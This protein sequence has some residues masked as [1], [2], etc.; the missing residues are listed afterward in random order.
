MRPHSYKKYMLA[1]LMAILAFNS[2]DRIALGIVLQ[3]IKLDF[4]LSDT[5]LGTLSGIAF[6][7]FYA[8]AGIPIARWADSGNRKVIIATTTALWSIAVALYGAAG[9]FLQLLGI[10]IAVAVGEAGCVPPAHSLIAD[11][12][13]RAERPRAVAIYCLGGPLALFV[14]YFSAGWLN[15]A[16]GWRATFVIIGLPGLALALVAALTLKEL[17]TARTLRTTSTT[18]RIESQAL[19]GV[20]H[21]N[22]RSVCQT[23]WSNLAFR[24]LL[25]SFSLSYFFGYGLLQW[26]P[27]Y[28]IRV[29]G[30]HTAELGVWMSLTYGITS[31]VGIYLGGELA[32]RYAAGNERLQLRVCSIAFIFFSGMTA[33][34]FLASDRYLAFT[35]LA[36]S[37]VGVNIVQGPMLATIQTLVPP[38]MRAMSIA[39]VYLFANLIGMGLGPLAAGALSDALRPWVAGESLRYSLLI[40]CP[41]YFWAAWHVWQASR[42]VTQELAGVQ[43]ENEPVSR[44]IGLAAAE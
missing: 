32:S 27:T 17:R 12:F 4:N 31:A 13:T 21:P 15:E 9:N 43:V 41:G 23:L 18:H 44:T 26:E 39:L 2:L 40:L 10:R 28:F 38:R 42:T 16:Y 11:Y 7:L 3:D 34:I 35:A 14:G 8:T 36:L 20:S 1:V 29:H 25:F 24:H 33:C 22:F 6:A 19:S 37:V 30:F 5:Q